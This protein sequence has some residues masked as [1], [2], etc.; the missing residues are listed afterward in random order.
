MTRQKSENPI[1]PEGVR[2]F[3]PIGR[4]GRGGKGVPVDEEG[5]AGTAI[6]NSRQPERGRSDIGGGPVFPSKS[7]GG[8]EGG[9][10]DQTD[11]PRDHGN[12]GRVPR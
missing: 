7:P 1:V 12:C 4:S 2:K 10:T 9:W 6:C 11:T 3:A 8:A 5:V